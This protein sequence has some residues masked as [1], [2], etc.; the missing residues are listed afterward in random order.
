MS[1][2]VAGYM[3]TAGSIGLYAVWLVRRIRQLDR[4]R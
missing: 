4:S 1:Y 3:L 2:V